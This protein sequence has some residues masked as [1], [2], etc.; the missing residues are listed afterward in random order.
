MNSFMESREADFN[1]MEENSLE[2]RYI[3]LVKALKTLAKSIN[4]S[5]D[6]KIID[7]FKDEIRDSKIQRFEYTLDAFWKYLADY[8]KAKGIIVKQLNPKDVFRAAKMD[9]ILTDAEFEI[10][11]D[12]VDDRNATSHNYAEGLSEE[13][14]KNINTYFPLLQSIT[15]KLTPDS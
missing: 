2:L 11:L 13:I 14:A 7:E 10:L 12:A 8:L 3:P 9:K 15:E 1:F 4:M 6:P 5:K